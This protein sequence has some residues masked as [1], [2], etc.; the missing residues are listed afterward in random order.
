MR[1]WNAV[2][3]LLGAALA[4]AWLAAR[5]GSPGGL[6]RR[7][8][9]PARPA[10]VSTGLLPPAAARAVDEFE[11]AY[12]P[13]FRAGACDADTVLRLAGLRD[14][15]V[16]AVHDARMRLPNDLRQEHQLARLAEE[17]EDR[18]TAQIQDVRQRCGVGL[19]PG[20]MSGWHAGWYR[21]GAA[22]D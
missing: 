12:A 7:A 8:A 20:R 13:T 4:W 16:G 3:V 19:L 21:A 11:A 22:A 1:P 14:R 18:M 10:P 17:T 5:P 15:A 6:V 9:R 2:A